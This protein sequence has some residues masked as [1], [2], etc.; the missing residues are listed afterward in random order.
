VK[1]YVHC[2]WIGK[3]KKKKQT[4]E[5]HLAGVSRMKK[6]R[7]SPEHFSVQQGGGKTPET[8]SQN[9]SKRLNTCQVCWMQQSL[10]VIVPNPSKE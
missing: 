9:T 3:D 7:Y 6:L 4:V 8:K 1:F 10:V 5:I 2:F